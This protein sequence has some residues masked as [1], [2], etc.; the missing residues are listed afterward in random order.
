MFS[1]LQRHRLCALLL[2]LAGLLGLL[3]ASSAIASH[4]VPGVADQV[5]ATLV[6]NFR[7][8]ITTTQCTSTGR[9]PAQHRPPL[10]LASCSPPAF[11]PGTVAVLG[12]TS[13][14]SVAVNA[15]PDDPTTASDET[16]Y[17]LFI[18]MNDVQ[19]LVTAPGCAGPG[20][21]YNTNGPNDVGV[22]YRIRISDHS[23]C[24]PTPCAAG[25][26]NP[27]TMIDVD[28]VLAVPVDCVPSGAPNM[29]PGSD[30]A[31]FTTINALIPDF[32]HKGEQQ[33]LQV[34]RARVKDSG[35]DGILGNGDD[36]DFVMQGLYNNG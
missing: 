20:A 8:T 5:D 25:F 2:V 34:F 36:R 21:D 13:N 17:G 10:S 33:I 12:P 30:C 11:I 24:K 3:S 26:V 19:C 9:Q 31:S 28:D 6:P 14:S 35:L 27:G 1:F 15:I 16:D 32:V 7:Q 22:R 29:P 18:L 4:P 23:N